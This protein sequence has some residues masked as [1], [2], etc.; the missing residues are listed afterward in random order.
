MRMAHQDRPVCVQA[1]IAKLSVE[2]LDMRIL[3]KLAWLNGLQHKFIS[4]SPV[5]LSNY[6]GLYIGLDYFPVLA[7]RASGERSRLAF[8]PQAI[9]GRSPLRASSQG[10]DVFL[11]LG[12]SQKYL[13][14]G[15]L[16]FRESVVESR[17]IYNDG[18][19]P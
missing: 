2:L 4:L 1:L 5:D 19:N 8:S 11:L 12:G 16:R 6:R 7:H 18:D 14:A 15:F 9:V 17:F 10:C 3:L 13:G